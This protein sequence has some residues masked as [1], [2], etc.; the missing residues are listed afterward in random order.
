MLGLG[1]GTKRKL[2]LSYIA[3]AI[4]LIFAVAITQYNYYRD[5]QSDIIS[6]RT[7]YARTI[8]GNVEHMV[9][10]MTAFE[11]SVGYTIYDNNYTR[12][13][14]S[15]YLAK[16]AKT[17]PVTSIDYVRLTGEIYASSD[18]SLV[19]THLNHGKY[20]VSDYVLKMTRNNDTVISPLHSHDYGVVSFDII[21]GIWRKKGLAGA[22]VMSV[23]ATKL[24]EVMPVVASR[25]DYNITDNHGML[26]YQ[27]QHPVMPLSGRNWSD[28]T[29]VSQALNGQEYKSNSVLFPVDFSTR[30]GA[31]VPVH[32]I[33]WTAGSFVPVEDAMAPITTNVIRTSAISILIIILALFI[34]MMVVVGVIRSLS[35]QGALQGAPQGRK[36][37]DN[38]ESVAIGETIQVAKSDEAV[39]LSGFESVDGLSIGKREYVDEL[40]GLVLAGERMNSAKDTES[41]RAALI[42]SLVEDFGVTAIWTALYN[43]T[44]KQLIVD[45]SWG[46]G[47]LNLEGRTVAPGEGVTGKVLMTAKPEVIDNVE[48]SEFVYKDALLAAG[49]NSAIVLPLV[50]GGGPIGIIG[51]HGPELGKGRLSKNEINLLMAIANQA[52]V[53]IENVRLFDDAHA[54]E[55]I[56]KTANESIRGFKKMSA[57][58]SAGLALGDLLNKIEGDA[59]ELLGA[60]FASIGVYDESMGKIESRDYVTNQNASA[61]IETLNKARELPADLGFGELIAK[62]KRTTYTN[63]YQNDSEANEIA[64]CLGVKAVVAAPVL[65]GGRLIG[66]LQIGW[67]ENK[68]LTESDIELIEAVCNNAAIVMDSAILR[69]RERRVTETL[70]NAL[71]VVPEKL[72][73][74]KV[75][76]MY[77]AASEKSGTGA[78]FYDFIEFKDGRIGL[79]VGGVSGT[80]LEAA[81]ITAFM[82]MAVRVSAYDYNSPA[83]V[84]EYLNYVVSNQLA[85]GSVVTMA[86]MVIDPET[87]DYSYA[88]AGHPEPIIADYATF[89][90]R[91]LEAGSLPLGVQSDAEYQIFDGNLNLGEALLLYTDGLTGAQSGPEHFGEERVAEAM[92]GVND[93]DVSMIPQRLVEA[94]EGFAG[95][96]LND[97]LAIVAVIRET[98]NSAPV[99]QPLSESRSDYGCDDVDASDASGSDDG[100]IMNLISE[101]ESGI[102]LSE[103]DAVSIKSTELTVIKGGSDEIE[104]DEPEID[105]EN[106]AIEDMIKLGIIET[107]VYLG[108]DDDYDSIP[109][110]LAL[111][112]MASATDENIGVAA[113][114]DRFAGSRASLTDSLTSDSD[115]SGA[116]GTDDA[117]ELAKLAYEALAS[118]AEPESMEAEIGTLEVKAPILTAV[119]SSENDLLEKDSDSGL[120]NPSPAKKTTKASKAAKQSPKKPNKSKEA[121]PKSANKPANKAANKAAKPIVEDSDNA[122]ANAVA[123]KSEVAGTAKSKTSSRKKKTQNKAV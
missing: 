46:P 111:D 11:K 102:D 60:D 30:I 114:D 47:N 39:A 98:A 51:L 91:Q 12:R 95:G 87:G 33:K 53:V 120:D 44:A 84:L 67:F 78:D 54:S 81:A 2:F 29:F 82:K 76:S 37:G 3:I 49:I 86:Y 73:G 70:Q 63:D 18:S 88:N 119:P 118:L 28:E 16:T 50:S 23:D 56:L 77:R 64:V 113:E 41:I 93:P 105:Y 38:S 21:T 19:G 26:V 107:D 55:K 74:V 101:L 45:Y 35:S 116:A 10:E 24:D 75:G 13:E 43:D 92:L 71:M 69:D 80:G 104:I 20:E 7:N 85:T 59:L 68:N 110:N 1:T 99:E 52:A 62:V 14:A 122:D 117:N 42:D 72:H 58:M 40:H 115:S 83:D 65:V 112:S 17:Y 31:Q 100:T 108:L 94:A 109:D 32:G 97:D 15:S 25:G 103:V 5:K 9:K 121:S 90:T 4:P 79:I 96:V 27:S 36:T 106:L 22:V 89:K 57:E 34:G 48:S 8:A 6:T 123:A 61:N 66:L